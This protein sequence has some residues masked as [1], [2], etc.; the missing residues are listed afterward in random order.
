MAADLIMAAI[1]KK[2]HVTSTTYH[3]YAKVKPES[4]SSL[5]QTY[6]LRT[7]K[8]VSMP[9]EGIISGIQV[10]HIHAYF[11]KQ[12]KSQ[13]LRDLIQQLEIRGVQVL[14]CLVME[15]EDLSVNR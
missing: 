5:G 7:D 13:E 2:D 4:F 11:T 15:Q 3:E 10:D 8:S 1:N 6:M 9:Q 12:L 14:S